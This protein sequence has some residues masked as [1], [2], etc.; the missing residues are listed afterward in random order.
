MV[1]ENRRVETLPRQKFD[2]ITARA[3][4]SLGQLFDWCLPYAGS[5]TKWILPKGIRVLDE[6]DLATAQFSF[7]HSLVPSHTDEDARIVVATGVKR[8]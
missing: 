5:G 1:I 3:L 4:A 7:D 8:R 2:V 6:I